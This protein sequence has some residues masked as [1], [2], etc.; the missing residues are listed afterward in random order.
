MSEYAGQDSGSFTVKF[1]G[2]RIPRAAS[3][4]LLKRSPRV[5]N[6]GQHVDL[7]TEDGSWRKGFRA[8]SEPWT[9]E[10]GEVVIWVATEDEYRA[11]GSEGRRAVGVPWPTERMVVSSPRLPWQLPHPSPPQPLGGAW[12]PWWRRVEQSGDLDLEILIRLLRN[13][14]YGAELLTQRLSHEVEQVG[15]GAVRSRLDRLETAGLVCHSERGEEPGT[16]KAERWKITDEGR[17][18][19]EPY[20]GKA[21]SDYDRYVGGDGGR[22]A[23]LWILVGIAVLTALAAAYSLLTVTGI[24]GGG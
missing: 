3:R 18:A 4:P 16:P 23:E 13:D 12:R 21:R 15:V 19:V 2:R 11:A 1:R 7:H 8:L 9:A 20:S 17:A 5:P 10:T 6:P 14:A 24:L 22:E